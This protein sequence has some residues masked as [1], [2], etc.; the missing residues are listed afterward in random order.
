[1]TMRTNYILYGGIAVAVILIAVIS[2]KLFK[3]RGKPGV[4]GPVMNKIQDFYSMQDHQNKEP[5]IN[6]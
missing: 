1:M 4:K 5:N 6:Y 3:N 2:Y